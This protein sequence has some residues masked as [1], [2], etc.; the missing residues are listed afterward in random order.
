LGKREREKGGRG[1][2]RIFP[3]GQRREPWLMEDRPKGLTRKGIYR[4]ATTIK[5][6][7]V[8]N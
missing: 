3:Y 7:T 1:E 6:S 5:I 4:A 8:F 2:G